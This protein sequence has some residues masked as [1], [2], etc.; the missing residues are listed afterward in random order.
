MVD[1]ESQTLPVMRVGLTQFDGGF[2]GISYARQSE[3]GGLEELRQAVRSQIVGG[4]E[5]VSF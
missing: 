3:R 5:K 1:K 2:R 4:L